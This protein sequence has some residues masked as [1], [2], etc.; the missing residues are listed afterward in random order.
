[1][2]PNVF[3][4]PGEYF[5]GNLHTHSNLSDG[6]LSPEEVCLRYKNEGYQF[7][8]LSDHLLGIYN[9]PIVD[10]SK[11]RDENFTTLLGA[12][13]HSGYMQNGEIW[14]ILAVG[15]PKDFILPNA[16]D[17]FPIENQETGPNLAKQI[18]R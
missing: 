9:Y 5:K 15:L 14:H 17:F 16:P 12:E 8:C 6:L 3:A 11:Y 7:I 18:S 10:T 4:N 13:V 2:R 1:M